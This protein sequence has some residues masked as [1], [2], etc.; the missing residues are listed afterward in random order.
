M[1]I[2]ATITLLERGPKRYGATLF[3]FTSSHSGRGLCARVAKSVG[4]RVLSGVDFVTKQV[5]NRSPI[6]D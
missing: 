3:V 6:V 4:Y 2:R 1:V 5:P